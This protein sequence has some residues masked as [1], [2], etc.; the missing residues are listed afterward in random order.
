MPF[1]LLI[2][3]LSVY[4]IDL[5]MEHRKVEGQ[6]FLPYN[7]RVGKIFPQLTEQVLATVGLGRPRVKAQK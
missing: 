1:R 5:V 4:F 7:I 2:C 6:S 3:L